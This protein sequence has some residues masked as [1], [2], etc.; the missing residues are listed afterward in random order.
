M[1]SCHVNGERNML[2]IRIVILVAAL[3]LAA[4][5][6]GFAAM[7]ASA[8]DRTFTLFGSA[9]GNNMGWG[10]TSSTEANPGPLL[11]A[12]VGDTVTITIT[13]T[14]SQAHNWF[15]DYDN[16]NSPTGT[17]PSTADVTGNSTTYTFT[18]DRAGT[19]TYRCRIHPTTMTG[20]IVIQPKALFELYGS[21]TSGSN[22][23]G[24]DEGSIS[25][26]GPTIT[27]DQG[28]VVTFDLI[29]QDGASHSLVI[30]YNKNGTADSGEPVSPTFSGSEILRWSFTADR[31]GTFQYFCGIHGAN[32]MNGTLVVRGTG[33]TTP[34]GIP[35]VIIGGVII[36]I[37]VVAVAAAV[38]MRRKKP[39]P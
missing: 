25:Q 1:T 20:T 19:F 37:A 30:D 29:A 5:S 18:P 24:F 38:L 31:A 17:E 10:N 32:T 4:V 9:T 15:I 2:R 14:D 33:G 16:S 21:A 3:A 7:P 8:A 34:S 28:T 6:T 36:V 22:G 26:P 13:G 35:L 12:S 11:V 39:G 27:V 23:W